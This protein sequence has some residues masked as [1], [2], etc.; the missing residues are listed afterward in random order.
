MELLKKMQ[1]IFAP[2]GEEESMKDFLINYISKNKKNWKKQPKLIYGDEFQNC[3]ILVFGKPRC[4]IFSHID[5][6]GFT[7]GYDNELIKL[8]GPIAENGIKLFG[9]DSQGKIN[10][11]I[12]YNKKT[13][14]I[15]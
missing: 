4:A 13:K 6:I 10:T 8:G 2:S 9:E 11:K 14:K 3:L 15:K 12:I 7:V 5:S 1:S